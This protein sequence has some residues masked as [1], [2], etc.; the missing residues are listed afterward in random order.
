MVQ[1]SLNSNGDKIVSEKIIDKGHK[2][3][4]DPTTTALLG[5]KLYV[6]ANSYLTEYNAN[7]ESVAGI[8]DKLGPVVVLVYDLK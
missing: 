7:K 3:F 6:L 5:N 8:S 2:T 1:N 4:H